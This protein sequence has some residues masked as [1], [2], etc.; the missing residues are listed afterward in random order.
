MKFK[1]RIKNS[2]KKIW[3]WKKD[4]NAIIAPDR[5][6]VSKRVHHKTLKIQTYV[7]S[8]IIFVATIASISMLGMSKEFQQENKGIP[9]FIGIIVFF[10]LLIDLT[11]RWYTSDV[12][13]KKG[14][15]SYVI[16]PFT[17]TGALL[18]ISLLPSLYLISL[19]TGDNVQF[20][21]IF[22]NMK[23]LR[24][25]RL[26]LLVNLV[27]SLG[28]FKRVLQ[29]EK[30][31]LY[32][33]FSIVMIAII[34]FALIMYNIEGIDSVKAQKKAIEL[35]NSN[36]EKHI[37][38]PPE[39]AFDLKTSGLTE[40]K[41]N[42]LTGYIK[43]HSLLDA[44]YFS[45]VALTTIG[46]GDITPITSTGKIIVMIMS[47]MG[48]AILATPSGVIAGGFISEVKYAKKHKIIK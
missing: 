21:D 26:I 4:L 14:N 45:T 36:N 43:I 11:L 40:L 22:R 38:L 41:F 9:L 24:L 16:F 23:F 2:D 29:K 10:I 33:V 39:K 18:I 31:T 37:T 27:P 8:I 19:V 25:F 15:W 5:T 7:Y 1:S 13:L 32:V 3:E 46:F 12:R 28:I 47:I 17:L 34:V 30:A 20:F 44:I 42:E 35:F 48:I 6:H